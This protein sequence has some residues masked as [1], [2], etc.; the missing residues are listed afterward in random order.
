MT[1]RKKVVLMFLNFEKYIDSLMLNYENNQTL[2]PEKEKT[3]FRNG[4][5]FVHLHSR[6]PPRP[7]TTA[8]YSPQINEK[9]E[10]AAPPDFFY[11]N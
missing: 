9:V 6:R 2:E 3:I 8:V 7:M 10:R 11:P 4:H 5:P 1:I